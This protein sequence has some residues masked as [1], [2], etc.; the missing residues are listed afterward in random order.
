MVNAIATIM[1]AAMDM[2]QGWTG[3]SKRPGKK[4]EA[5]PGDLFIYS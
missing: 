5:A 3:A 4:S 2:H 1:V